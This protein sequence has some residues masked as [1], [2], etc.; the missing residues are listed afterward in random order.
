M[1]ESFESLFQEVD[2]KTLTEPEVEKKEEIIKALKKDKKFVA[3]YGSGGMY[4][5]A[6]AQAEK[7]A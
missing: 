6:T 4:A 2:E 5:V 1:D 3:K 7:V